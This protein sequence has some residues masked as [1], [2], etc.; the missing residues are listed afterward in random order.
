MP[1]ANVF[2]FPPFHP[3][4]RCTVVAVTASGERIESPAEDGIPRYVMADGL[5]HVRGS[6]PFDLLYPDMRVSLAE[7]DPGA[8]GLVTRELAEIDSIFVATAP[9]IAGEGLLRRLSSLSAE[10]GTEENGCLKA[11]AWSY[12]NGSG[13]V[14]NT[15][16]FSDPEKIDRVV[17]R[18]AS[19]NIFLA[20]SV[21][22]PLR[23]VLAHEYGHQVF[24]R[25][26]DHARKTLEDVFSAMSDAAPDD[27]SAVAA[28]NVLEA[29][30]ESF[31]CYILHNGAFPAS[32]SPWLRKLF[33]GAQIPR[34]KY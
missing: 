10:A 11:L 34:K 26:P 6:I 17:A 14:L 13:I 5:V 1:P 16:Y 32:A 9:D 18:N 20:E 21:E 29:F 23:Y 19:R 30:A 15:R 12:D 27:I 33:A 22:N 2:Y 25:L 28:Q 24:A 31:A 7:L 3:N 4:C 8:V